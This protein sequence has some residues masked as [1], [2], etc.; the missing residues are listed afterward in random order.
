MRH[1]SVSATT[2]DPLTTMVSS[3]L[4]IQS[5]VSRTTHLSKVPLDDLVDLSSQQTDKL[6]VDKLDDLD[7]TNSRYVEVRSLPKQWM[8]GNV[9]V[10][11]CPLLRS[12]I[13]CSLG[14]AAAPSQREMQTF[15]NYKQGIWKTRV[16]WALDHH[17]G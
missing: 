4:S 6:M 7:R 2:S 15:T 11:E 10:S 5:N 13:L 1:Q 9:S 17:K 16:S 8:F 3:H 12:F 14:I